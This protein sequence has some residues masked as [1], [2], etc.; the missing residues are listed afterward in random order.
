MP[1]LF[2][3]PF[4]QNVSP[5]PLCSTLFHIHL[6][7]QNTRFASKFYAQSPMP[8]T[9]SITKKPAPPPGP[10]PLA[11]SPSSSAP[12]APPAQNESQTLYLCVA[13]RIN[14][15][16]SSHTRCGSCVVSSPWH[17]SLQS[18]S[19]LD[20]IEYELMS[21]VPRLP[22]ATQ[23]K[24][25]LDMGRGGSDSESAWKGER[26]GIATFPGGLALLA[27]GSDDTTRGGRRR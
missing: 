20:V 1:P 19:E 24:A 2:H 21:F 22:I 4:L 18:H 10:A 3:I 5:S 26:R 17:T 9:M 25:R 16:R 27:S 7:C 8:L 23:L 6:S 11:A 13:C 12:P 15:V 14:W